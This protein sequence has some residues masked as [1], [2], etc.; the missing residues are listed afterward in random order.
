M[1]DGNFEGLIKSKA[2]VHDSGEVFT[3]KHIVQDICNLDGIKEASYSLTK[4]ILEPSCGNGN[5]LVE[6]V[7]RKLFIAAKAEDL[8]T[9]KLY[10]IMGL[11]TIYGVDIQAD[12]VQEARN[13][14]FNQVDGAYKQF[15]GDPDQD[16]DKKYESIVKSILEH[17]IVFGDALSNKMEYLKFSKDNGKEKTRM[18]KFH[19]FGSGENVIPLV[20]REY[21]FDGENV[22]VKAYDI[23]SNELVIDYGKMKYE[24]LT[25]LP[26]EDKDEDVE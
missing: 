25:R 22:A 21:T 6:L 5:F 17:N 8:E 23:E 7:A 16:L 19:T 26:K 9:Y 14:I 1:S 4:R 3:P 10:S 20:F 24:R 11:S 12:N 13:R 15:T 18:L 2:R